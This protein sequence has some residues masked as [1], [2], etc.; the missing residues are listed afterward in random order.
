MFNML[1]SLRYVKIEKYNI[2]SFV[3]LKFYNSE[4]FQIR[5]LYTFTVCAEYAHEH[6]SRSYV[7]VQVDRVMGAESGC[8]VSL[9]VD[10]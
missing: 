2:Y 8:E 10:V 9:S 7:I 4:Q 3:I 6:L 5:I 1:R